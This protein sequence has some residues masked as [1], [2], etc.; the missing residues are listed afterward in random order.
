MPKT[1]RQITCCYCDAATFVDLTKIGR[2][3]L[4]CDACGARLTSAKMEA[5]LNK[6]VPVKKGG[7][8]NSGTLDPRWLNVHGPF[9]G[10]A[11]VP[12]PKKRPKSKPRPRKRKGLFDRLDDVWDVIEDIID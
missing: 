11:A 9:G 2:G 10:G 4:T 7:T 12:Q 6:P 1:V 5:V 8:R 3:V